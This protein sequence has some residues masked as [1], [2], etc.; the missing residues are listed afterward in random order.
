MQM[1]CKIMQIK[2]NKTKYKYN[3]YMFVSLTARARMVG[4]SESKKSGNV[5]N[6]RI[7]AF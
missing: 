4:R 5:K 6:K 1:Q 3:I 7:I 2:L